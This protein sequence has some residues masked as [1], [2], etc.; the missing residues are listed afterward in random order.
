MEK[1]KDVYQETAMLALAAK[2]KLIDEAY[3]YRR[4]W[5][6][7]SSCIAANADKIRPRGDDEEKLIDLAINADHGVFWSGKTKGWLS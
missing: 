2:S 6:A 3:K 4:L 1:D 5:E 7:A